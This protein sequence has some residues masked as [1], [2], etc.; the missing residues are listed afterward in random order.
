MVPAR[1]GRRCQ[2]SSVMKGIM[3]CSSLSPAS[4]AVYKA[5]CACFVLPA[6]F[7]CTHVS[8]AVNGRWRQCLFMHEQWKLV[9]LWRCEC[10]SIPCQAC[11]IRTLRGIA[12]TS[13]LRRFHVANMQ[14]AAEHAERQPKRTRTMVLMRSMNASHTSSFQNA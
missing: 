3:G 1:R 9:A 8:V 4:S 13:G 10:V 5:S 6:S 2:S 11:T 14:A 7:P 12:E